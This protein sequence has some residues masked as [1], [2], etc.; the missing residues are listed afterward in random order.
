MNWI[1]NKYINWII[2][3]NRIINFLLSYLEK[4]RMIEHMFTFICELFSFY[5]HMYILGLD[6]KTC[7]DK[8]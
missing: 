4:H 2:N 5:P 1:I 7:L 6:F 8:C 3:I